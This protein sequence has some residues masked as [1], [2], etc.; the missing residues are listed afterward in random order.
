[1]SDSSTQQPTGSKQLQRKVNRSTFWTGSAV[2]LW[3]IPIT[4]SLT[5][6]VDHGT[7]SM[8]LTLAAAVS[9]TTF[10]LGLILRAQARAQLRHEVAEERARRDHAEVMALIARNQAETREMFGKLGG[11]IKRISVSVMQ[12]YF[13]SYGDGVADAVGGPAVVNGTETRSL[14]DVMRG[15]SSGKVVRMPRHSGNGNG[16]WRK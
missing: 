11:E 3:L 8:I 9:I 6:D 7:F 2:M 4:L 5:T 14:D 12:D 15:S 13:N 16:S 1:M 10:L